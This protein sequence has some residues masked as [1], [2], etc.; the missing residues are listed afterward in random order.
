L[1]YQSNYKYEYGKNIRNVSDDKEQIIYILLPLIK[2]K[3]LFS[4]L[5]VIHSSAQEENP[6]YLAVS[7]G[8][9]EMVRLLLDRGSNIG[10][11]A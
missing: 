11:T 10:E 6:L 4:T 9:M 5:F 3:I 8:H 7:G 1:F 2:L